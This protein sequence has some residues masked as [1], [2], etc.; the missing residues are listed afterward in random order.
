MVFGSLKTDADLFNNVWGP[1]RMMVWQN[2]VDA[3]RIADLGARI[4]NS[5]I[6][7]VLSLTVLL[8]VSSIAA[9]ALARL[10]FPGPA[11]DLSHHP[12]D[13]DDPA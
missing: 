11:G 7:T 10:Q 3:W 5:I 12:G 8:I 9:Y 13:H 4:G 2:Y 1:P 6:I